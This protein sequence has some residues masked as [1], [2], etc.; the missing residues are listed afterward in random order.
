MR[1]FQSSGI[2]SFVKKSLISLVVFGTFSQASMAENSQQERLIESRFCGDIQHAPKVCDSGSS[3]CRLLPNDS[4]AMAT[5][6]SISVAEEKTVAV[7]GGKC[8][9]WI[10]VVALEW[11]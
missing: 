11:W 8:L 3:D 5:L 2:V 4:A 7:Q 6:S 1:S 9:I 10:P